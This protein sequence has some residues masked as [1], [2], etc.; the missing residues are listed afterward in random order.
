MRSVLR[1]RVQSARQPA[2]RMS[3][4]LR[5]RFTTIKTGLAPNVSPMDEDMLD[6]WADLA[7]RVDELLAMLPDR[8]KPT[9]AQITEQLRADWV[10]I[11]H[12]FVHY[13]SASNFA[14]VMRGALA[15]QAAAAALRAGHNETVMRIEAM[16]A[17]ADV[18]AWPAIV[19]ECMHRESLTVAAERAIQAI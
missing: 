13:P 2:N 3:P 15:H 7:G 5:T 1:M 19:Y 8:P 6:L 4:D 9:I 10:A 17:D 14:Q 12:H 18:N 16:A 11:A